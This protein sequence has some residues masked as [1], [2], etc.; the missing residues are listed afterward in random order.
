MIEN[1]IAKTIIQDYNIDNFS[2][3]NSECF[4]VKRFS[5]YE[6]VPF[7]FI[8]DNFDKDEII[9]QLDC[10]K[11]IG[12]SAFFLHVRDGIVE[13][14]YGTEL[15]FNNVK[16][17]IEKAKERDIKVWLYDED[18][19]PSGNLGGKIVIDRPELQAYALKVIKVDV[20]EKGVARKVLGRVKGLYGYIVETNN[21]KEKVKVLDEN[22][23]T[24]RK[25]WYKAEVDRVYC[26]DL[27]DLSYKHLRGETNYTEIVFE[28]KAP[29]GCEVFVA[30]LEPVF[31][32]QRFSA[33]ADC[34]NIETTKIFINNTHEKYRKYVGEY[35]GKE[36]PGIFL[37]E[38]N[39]GG[40]LPYT[41][42]LPKR[43][44][45]DYGYRLENYY[46]KLCSEYQGDKAKLRR[47]YAKT[48]NDLFSEN[49]VAP[50]KE[51]CKKNNLI[52]TGHY[53]GEELLF[54]QMFVGQNVYKN[55]KV[56]DIPG[57]D[58]IT[59]NIGSAKRPML[60]AGANMVVSAATHAKKQTVLSECFALFPFDMGYE[61]LKREG[62]WLFVN[63]INKLVPHAFHYGYSA[64][65]RADA[66]KSFFFQD[67]KF[68]E[69]IKFAEYAGRCCKLLC[70]L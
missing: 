44:F 39:V 15:F 25:N 1:T 3:G 27:Q 57:Y 62:D 8:N 49:F 12:I 22:F 2:F 58:I 34:L 14:G 29:R 42:A 68:D 10:M 64:F 50:I 5:S 67:A 51:W 56:S 38:P 30:Y 23:G 16:F 48:C 33:M 59:Y 9:L 61:G 47:D 17:I 43:F 55:S 54:W 21:G 11:G 18:S 7:W 26:S 66:G 40:I 46:Y 19:Y 45:S 4:I 53:G 6:P 28:T 13:E 20:N 63:G 32:D 52:M 69:Y 35:F 41:E 37:D 36:I 31:V 60:L 24:I 65:Q 70:Y